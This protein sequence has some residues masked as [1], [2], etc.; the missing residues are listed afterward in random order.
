MYNQ[1]ISETK[2]TVL[3]N[4]LKEY[5]YFLRKVFAFAASLYP[6]YLYLKTAWLAYCHKDRTGQGSGPQ[7]APKD[8]KKEVATLVIEQ[9][10]LCEPKKGGKAN[11]KDA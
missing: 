11:K 4:D 3:A 1:Y 2:D 8:N 5:I 7:K 10:S 6:I 9:W